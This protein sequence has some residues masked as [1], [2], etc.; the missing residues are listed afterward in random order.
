[1]N[2]AVAKEQLRLVKVPDGDA[3]QLHLKYA[4]EMASAAAGDYQRAFK[5][6]AAFDG[7]YSD[8]QIRE[9]RLKAEVAQLRLA[10]WSNPGINLLSLLDHMHWQIERV[11][12]EVLD[13]QKRVEKLERWNDKSP[14]RRQSIPSFMQIVHGFRKAERNQGVGRALP[15]RLSVA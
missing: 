13:L 5:A 12:E 9:L 15:G 2:V 10:I 6:K 8:L 14:I 11:S 7:A 3:I 1:M 4:Q